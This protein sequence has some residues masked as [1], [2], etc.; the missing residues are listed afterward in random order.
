MYVRSCVSL[1]SCSLSSSETGMTRQTAPPAP[2]PSLR[3]ALSSY[4]SRGAEALVQA[5]L[6]QELQQWSVPPNFPKQNAK[7][8]AALLL[9]AKMNHGFVVQALLAT[10]AVDPNSRDRSRDTALDVTMLSSFNHAMASWD[11]LSLLQAETADV[12]VTPLHLAVMGGNKDM[13]NMIVRGGADITAT[14]AWGLTPLHL[15]AMMTGNQEIV[16]LLVRQGADILTRD[17]FR[18]TALD[19]AWRSE[20]W[21][22]VRAMWEALHGQLEELE[23]GTHPVKAM[24]EN[25]LVGSGMNIPDLVLGYLRPA[26]K[27]LAEN[28]EVDIVRNLFKLLHWYITTFATAPQKDNER[29]VFNDRQ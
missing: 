6:I 28:I 4:L 29:K 22:N 10:K 7:L 14:T 2:P 11:V 8:N 13:V 27:D 25:S 1:V 15:A 17:L 3:K 21:I 12:G 19:V 24:L 26:Q 16:G 20:Q 5:H 18:L 23:K 9:S